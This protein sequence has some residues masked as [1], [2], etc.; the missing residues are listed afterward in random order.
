M[1]GLGREA[2]E[3]MVKYVPKTVGEMKR[4][5]GLT[6]SDVLSVFIHVSTKIVPRGTLREKLLL[7]D[8]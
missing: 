7:E 5:P 4:I 6:P 8:E 3:K 2:I 1:P